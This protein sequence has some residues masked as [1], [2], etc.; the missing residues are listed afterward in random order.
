MRERESLPYFLPPAGAEDL[1]AALWARAAKLPFWT[2]PP[3]CFA[4]A[5][6]IREAA[7]AVIG[8]CDPLPVPLGIVCLSVVD[9]LDG[10]LKKSKKEIVVLC[11]VEL[12]FG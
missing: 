5:D 9:L 2:P 4:E 12:F 6:W 7:W 3:D 1:A 11:S 8:A 10:N